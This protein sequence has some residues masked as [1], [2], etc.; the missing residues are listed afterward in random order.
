MRIRHRA[1]ASEWFDYLMPTLEEL[2]RL[3]DPQGWRLDDS[4]RAPGMSASGYA[5]ELRRA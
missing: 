4:L 5:V 1:I 3:V 2:I